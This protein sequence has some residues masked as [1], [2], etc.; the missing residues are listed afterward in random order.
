MGDLNLRPSNALDGLRLGI[1]VSASADL[2]ML[3]LHPRHA[4]L[5]LAEIARS[6]L[7]LSGR[8]VYGGRIK[9]PGYT[10]FLLSELERYGDHPD[11]L[12]LCLAAPEH[13]TLTVK[14]LKGL[15]N[16]LQTRG[17]VVCLSPSGLPMEIGSISE[18]PE[19]Q[20]SN[21][22][23]Y[24]AM[25]QYL[26]ENTDAQVILGGKLEQFQGS[27]PGVIE[28]AINS[29]KAEQPLYIVGGFGGAAALVAKTLEIDS[30]DWAPSNYP[31][32]PED[33]RIEES[34]HQLRS[35]VNQSEASI[36]CCGLD[37]L[38]LRRLSTTHRPKEI[39]S[40]IANGL[41]AV[42]SNSR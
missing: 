30:F 27:M 41:S 6:V 4:Q 39:A 24:S 29:I 17:R 15:N 37:D 18:L 7:L 28:E 36:R 13:E 10:Q 22:S 42:H 35:A 21:S 33:N 5:A 31:I 14:E 1:S 34:L 2:P 3:G 26:C 20:P 8:L 9:P 32:R 25:R 12:T 23:S 11:S 40:I 16:K 38:D 19:K